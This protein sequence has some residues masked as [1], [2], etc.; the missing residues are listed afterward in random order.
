MKHD[1]VYLLKNDYDSEE[2]KYSVRSVVQNFPF[3][4]LVIVGG[5]PEDMRADILIRDKQDGRT[6]WERTMHSLKL[7]VKNEDLTEDIWIFNDDFFVMDRVRTETNYFNGTLEKRIIDL[8]RKNPTSSGYIRSLEQLKG[9][10]LCSNKDTLSFALHVPFLVNR[11]QAEQ[12]FESHPSLTMFRSFYGNY[13]KI[14]CQYMEDVKVYDFETV[15]DT[16]Y[17]STT[18]ETFKNGKVGEFLRRYFDKPSKYEI[19]EEEII[20]RER[21]TEEGEIRYES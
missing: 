5:C 6:K 19:T 10:L 4:K 3:R 12:L 21:Y 20:T 18:D 7:A 9:K 17:I 16:P 14:P 11:R 2:M 13:F 1:I 8:K 15:P